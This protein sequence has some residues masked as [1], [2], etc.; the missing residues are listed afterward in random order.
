MNLVAAEFTVDQR[1]VCLESAE[2]AHVAV[3]LS[4]AKELAQAGRAF[5]LSF[6]V[7]CLSEFCPQRS[8]EN[9]FGTIATKSRTVFCSGIE[10]GFP[11]SANQNALEDPP[12]RFR[13]RWIFKSFVTSGAVRIAANCPKET[14][15]QNPSATRSPPALTNVRRARRVDS[16][17]GTAWPRSTRNGPHCNAAIHFVPR[18]NSLERKI[19]H[20]HSCS[21]ALRLA[22]APLQTA[23]SLFHPLRAN[24][25]VRSLGSK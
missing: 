5:L 13:A 1:I 14:G 16:N 3:I 7:K 24:R 25:P 11:S 9:H 2:S 10:N 4:E 6:Q 23:K 19:A 15:V 20:Y 12:S 8:A 21:R 22:G 17:P 18:G